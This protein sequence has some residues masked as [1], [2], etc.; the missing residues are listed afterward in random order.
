LRRNYRSTKEIDRAAFSVLIPNL[1]FAPNNYAFRTTPLDSAGRNVFLDHPLLNETP[2]AH[3]QVTAVYN[4]NSVY[5]PANMLINLGPGG[6]DYDQYS[7]W[8]E[9]GDGEFIPAGAAFHILVDPQQSRRC[10][11]DLLYTSDFEQ[12]AGP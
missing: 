12:L 8:L 6:T 10:M 3:P 9:R 1:L 4:P 2:C 5:V 7:W 11:E